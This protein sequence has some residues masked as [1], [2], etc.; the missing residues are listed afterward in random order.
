MSMKEQMN[1]FE[2]SK[3]RLEILFDDKNGG[4]GVTVRGKTTG[5]QM[6]GAIITLVEK[7]A[8]SMKMDTKDVLAMVGTNIMMNDLLGSIPDEAKEK[9]VSEIKQ[10]K[11]DLKDK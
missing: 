1:A 3:D 9:I 10:M 6:M 5:E 8:E 2:E 7:F 11:K 4:T